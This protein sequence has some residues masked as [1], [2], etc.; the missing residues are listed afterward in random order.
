MTL[1]RLKLVALCY[2]DKSVTGRT[3]DRFASRKGKSRCLDFHFDHGNCAASDRSVHALLSVLVADPRASWLRHNSSIHISR[4]KVPLC[5]ARPS[6]S[7]STLYRSRDIS[8][9]ASHLV[10]ILNHH[11]ISLKCFA[12]RLRPRIPRQNCNSCVQYNPSCA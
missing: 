11:H 7:I 2:A 3:A 9:K 8:R 10:Y 6:S 4:E 1:R 5:L 12:R